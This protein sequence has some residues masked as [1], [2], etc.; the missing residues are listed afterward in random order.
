[1]FVGT[2]WCSTQSHKCFALKQSWCFSV[3]Q[4]CFLCAS[5]LPHTVLKRHLTQG[6]IFNK[7][8]NVYHS[9]E[10]VLRWN[11]NWQVL[12]F[13]FFCDCMVKYDYDTVW[14]H[15]PDWCW[16]TLSFSRHCF[17]TI[18]AN[19]NTVKKTNNVLV[20]LWPFGLPET[21]SGTHSGLNSMLLESGD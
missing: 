13:F 4:E 3:Q 7:I 2:R 17:C 12:F 6:L 15:C 18:I 14:R 21:V 5:H 10:N 20:L 1:M 8:R 11:W 9:V 16:D 19:V